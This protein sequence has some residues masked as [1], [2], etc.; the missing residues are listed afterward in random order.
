MQIKI[1]DLSFYPDKSSS[2]YY[3][4][5]YF[6]WYRGIEDTSKDNNIIFYTDMCF[7]MVKFAPKHT[8][9]M[10]FIIEPRS[11]CPNIYEWIKDNYHAFDM[12]ITH[13]ISLLTIDNRFKYVP[14]GGCWIKEENF[15]LHNKTKNISIIASS[16]N[17]TIGHN[18]RSN[19]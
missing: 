7:N 1:N 19:R 10:A 2:K 4:P 3:S 15:G 14:F 8:F 5:K 13:D 11:I 17:Y 9:K 18:L 12:V 6:E 16:K